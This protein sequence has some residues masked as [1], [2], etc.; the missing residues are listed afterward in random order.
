MQNKIK[1]W[2]L[3]VVRML[4][5]AGLCAGLVTGLPLTSLAASEDSGDDYVVDESG[6]YEDDEYY[7]EYYSERDNEEA[8][9][10]EVADTDSEAVYDEEGSGE[11]DDA[12]IEDP[13]LKYENEQYGTRLVV[14]DMEDLF[15]DEETRAFIESAE[16][17]MKYANVAV[18]TS[19]AGNYEQY[20]KELLEWYF[21]AGSDS[22]LFMINMDPRKIYI[23]SEGTAKNVLTKN[24]ALSVTDNVYRQAGLGAYYAC[25]DKALYQEAVL[26]S[27][28]RILEPMKYIGNFFLAFMIA[29]L[30]TFVLTFTLMPELKKEA[31]AGLE[32]TALAAL[33]AGIAFEFAN[34]ERIYDPVKSSD[35]DSSSGGSS[36][37]SSGAGGGHS[38]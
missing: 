5:L 34:E 8:E 15:S 14:D 24:A 10:D 6:G 36:G 17:V 11:E 26:L 19:A 1:R 37:G 33:A 25:A 16:G 9:E 2:S 13:D 22:T 20:A 4:V 23:Y 18:V 28:G 21:G 3:R 38:F 29:I 30:A 12:A 27:G 7:D 32:A 35:S 31:I